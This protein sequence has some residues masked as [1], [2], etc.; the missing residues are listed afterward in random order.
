MK[1]NNFDIAKFVSR[2]HDLISNK[3]KLEKLNQIWMPEINYIFSKV[4]D[5]NLKFQHQWLQKWHWLAYSS[6]LNGAFCKFCVIF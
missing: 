1:S 4:G 3:E 2:S 5:R 6:L